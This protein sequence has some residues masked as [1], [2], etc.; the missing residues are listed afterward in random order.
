MR[1]I[2]RISSRIS[3]YGCQP[4]AQDGR[5][6]ASEQR[7][8]ASDTRGQMLLATGLILMLALLTMSLNT[9][10]VASLGSPYDAAEDAVLDTSSEVLAAWQP[11]L[12]NRTD[13][14]IAAGMSDSDAVQAAADSVVADLMRHGEIRGV[15]VILTGISITNN[16]GIHTITANAG[17]ADRHARMEFTISATIDLN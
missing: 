2:R 3:A 9:I 7:G 1:Q 4:I 15:E 5:G 14:H 16:S 10:R 6:L 12:E 11:L 13:G 17:I 8:L